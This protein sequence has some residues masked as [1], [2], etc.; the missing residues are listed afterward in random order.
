MVKFIIIN[1]FKFYKIFLGNCSKR[2]NSKKISLID[3]ISFIWN[4]VKNK[5][6]S[7]SILYKKNKML[8]AFVSNE[9]F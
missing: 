6:K 2:G 7:F 3:V 5:E 8:F 9:N 4:P 1:Y